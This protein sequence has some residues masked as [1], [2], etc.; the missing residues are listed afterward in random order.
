MDR[1]LRA[2]SFYERIGK[3]Y[4]KK[5]KGIAKFCN[6]LVTLSDYIILIICMSSD[7]CAFC[8]I[9]SLFYAVQTHKLNKILVYFARISALRTL[10][11][12]LF[13]AVGHGQTAVGAVEYFKCALL[14]IV[15]LDLDLYFNIH[16]YKAHA[17]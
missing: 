6:A 15:L 1:I 9:I 12:A 13:A 3:K 5:H 7:F 8:M 4:F 17:V 14:G 10:V 2:P 11:I 16:S